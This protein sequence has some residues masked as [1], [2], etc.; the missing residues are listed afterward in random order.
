[1]SSEAVRVI[2]RCRP[3]NSREK[4]LKC[5]NVVQVD[6]ERNQIILKNSIAT[7]THGKQD[8]PF[9]FDGSYGPNSKTS[10]IYA[11]SAASL[12]ESVIEGFNATVFAYGQ[13][14]CGKSFTMEGP[15][16]DLPIDQNE[17]A[18]IIPR[19][20]ADLFD[21]V[22]LSDSGKKFLVHAS[23]LEIYNENV[24]DLLADKNNAVKPLDLKEHPD[25]GVYVKGLT[26]HRI[27][28]AIQAQKLMDKG[29]SQRATGETLMNQ[30]SSRSHAIFTIYRR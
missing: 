18:G 2:V 24:R 30:D 14:G 8:K 10:T 19:A 3:E 6:E 7:A 29:W 26:M 16:S 5:K 1:M 11:E 27:T 9:T 4:S 21:S 28:T 17:M 20:C 13:T 22:A 15:T 12:I 25:R 23:Y